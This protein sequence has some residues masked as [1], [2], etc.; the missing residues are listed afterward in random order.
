MFDAG[1]ASVVTK[2]KFF[3]FIFQIKIEARIGFLY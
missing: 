1:S 2:L 3:T